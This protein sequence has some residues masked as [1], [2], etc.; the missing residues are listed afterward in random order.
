MLSLAGVCKCELF[1]CISFT[2]SACLLPAFLMRQTLNVSLFGE[3][4]DLSQKLKRQT[5]SVLHEDERVTSFP[6]LSQAQPQNCSPIG[7]WDSNSCSLI[8]RL[9]RQTLRATQIE[10]REFN[11]G[12]CVYVSSWRSFLAC[13]RPALV[14]VVEGYVCFWPSGRCFGQCVC[15]CVW[16]TDR[17]FCL[18]VETDD[19]AE[20]IDEE[21]TYTM[22]SSKYPHSCC[23]WSVCV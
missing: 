17:F 21:D 12:V 19:Y 23:L 1:Y 10:F 2:W 20:I 3:E 16:D 18:P 9:D 11:R 14:S 15:V 4:R 22:P 8:G 6:W 7:R 13:F 5:K